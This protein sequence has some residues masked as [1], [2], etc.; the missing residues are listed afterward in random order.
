MNRL[1]K[2]ILTV[3]I[4]AIATVASGD[5]TLAKDNPLPT[6]CPYGHATLKRVKIVY[7][8]PVHD[9]KMLE[10]VRNHDIVFG[11]CVHDRD[12]PDWAAYCTSCGFKWGRGSIW[13]REAEDPATF[14]QPFSSLIRSFP[15]SD[16]SSRTETRYSQSTR[17]AAVISERLDFATNES[18]PALQ[19]KVAKW[20]EFNGIA[21]T[22]PNTQ[23]VETARPLYPGGP[24]V[25]ERIQS[26]GYHDKRP[27]TGHVMLIGYPDE[28][29]VRVDVLVTLSLS[30]TR[31]I[32][33][34]LN[35]QRTQSPPAAKPDA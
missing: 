29:K 28:N 32:D 18:L 35:A 6:I 24:R 31:S 5:T 4:G 23:P 8:L 2:H 3:V 20:A 30:D 26:W 22:P 7:G 34:A 13:E 25:T 9:A 16:E 1:R 27:V 15:I 33:D 14:R 12:S 17:G 11:G 21:L 10:A 19:E